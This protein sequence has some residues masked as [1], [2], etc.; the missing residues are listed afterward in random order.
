MSDNDKTDNEIEGNEEKT[1]LNLD[2]NI[3]AVL[4]YLGTIVTGIIL[5]MIEKKNNFVRFHAM[6]STLFFAGVWIASQVVDWFP[7]VGWFLSGLVSA[8]GVVGWIFLMFKAYNNE[9]FKL[10]FIGDYAEKFMKKV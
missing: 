9:Y 4:A 3:T 1:A 10:P 2:Q 8:L 5:L 7:I 6:Q